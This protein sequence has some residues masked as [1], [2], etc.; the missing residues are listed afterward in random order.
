MCGIFGIIGDIEKSEL[1]KLSRTIIESIVHRGPDNQAFD[2]VEGVSLGHTRLSIRDLH[3]RSNQPFYSKN[4]R[5]CIVYNGEIYNEK[6]LRTRL[7]TSL[8]TSSDTELVLKAFEKWGKDCLQYL[9]GMFSFAIYDFVEEEMFAVRDRFG[10]KP[11]YYSYYEDKFVFSSEF[12]VFKHIPWIPKIIDKQALYSYL[13]F[14]YISSPKTINKNISKLDPG[15]FLILR[16][17]KLRIEKYW[18]L[19]TSIDDLEKGKKQDTDRLSKDSFESLLVDSV[20]RRCVSDVPLGTYLS[21]GVD[22][23][24]ITAVSK[25]K[26]KNLKT[27]TIQFQEQG[28][29]ELQDA[30]TVSKALGCENISSL[31]TQKRVLTSFE[32]VIESMNEPFADSS[33]FS[34]YFLSELASKEVKVVLTGDGADEL[35]GGYPTYKLHKWS[36]YFSFSPILGLLKPFLRPSTSHNSSHLMM[37]QYFKGNKE[38]LFLKNNFWMGGFSR[39]EINRLVPSMDSNAFSLAFV[40][41]KVS[42]LS[43]DCARLDRMNQILYMDFHMYLQN[44]ILF[45]ADQANMCHGVE[46]RVPFLDHR[47]VTNVFSMSSNKKLDLFSS[48]KIIKEAMPSEVPKSVY[49]KEKRGFSLPIGHWIRSDFK[50]LVYEMLNQCPDFI[51]RSYLATLIE[52][53]YLN[54]ADHQRSIWNL[55]ILF[56]W[57]RL[58][59]YTI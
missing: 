34:T 4:K 37:E 26:C 41:S 45:K 56:N 52:E 14:N 16:K 27:F 32:S 25:K 47:L 15:H 54:K 30:L 18:T 23:S 50:E 8:E 19:M 13:A 35:A 39:N 57:L 36:K 49:R 3:E 10:I 17:G 21:G 5:Y 29:D 38:S 48:K 12:N 33:F 11:F 28:F 2:V 6:E 59:K 7:D 58:N 51:D 40:E 42:D 31:I 9:N 20:E 1:T 55:L 43:R 22:S 24:L 44:D 53:H 46:A